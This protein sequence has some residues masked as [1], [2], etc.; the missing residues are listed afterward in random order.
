M[1]VNDPSFSTWDEAGRKKTSVG[2]SSVFSSPLSISGESYQNAA[3]STST[4]SRT[5]SQSSFASPSRCSFPFAEP[6]AGFSPAI[7]YPLTFPSSI[8]VNVQYSEWSSSIF[9]R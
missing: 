2:I 6:T 7:R 1:F 8:W 4:R 3:V 5:T 9:G